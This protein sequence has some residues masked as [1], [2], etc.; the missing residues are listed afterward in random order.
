[1]QLNHG[2]YGIY[3]PIGPTSHDIINT[4][5][6][7]S[8]VKRV[9]HAGTLDPFASGV[10]VVAI[11]RE[12]TKQLSSIVENEKLYNAT[13]DLSARSTTDDLTGILSP[14]SKLVPPSL[15]RIQQTLCDFVGVIEQTPPIYS[16][17][18]VRGKPAH[19]RVRN[20]ESVTLFPRKV[21]I[22]S[23][24]IVSYSWPNLF[25]KIHTKKGVYIRAIARDIGNKLGVGG[26][27][28]A[29]ERIQVGQF[30]I[31]QALRIL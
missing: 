19:R 21:E 4:V 9:G 7:L 10:L 23:I 15:E 2:I 17:I 31:N 26:Y 20:G 11:G 12:Y 30:T 5:R 8:G 13:L 16:A 28:T 3:K 1:M 18:K 27:L 22:L 25:L 29:L 14:L 24:N 6:R